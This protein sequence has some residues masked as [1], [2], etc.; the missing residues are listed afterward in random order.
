[1]LNK[2]LYLDTETNGLSWPCLAKVVAVKDTF[3]DK[4]FFSKLDT[5]EERHKLEEVIRGRTVIGWNVGFD[6]SMLQAAGVDVT[7]AALWIDGCELSRLK[8]SDW[9]SYRLKD[10]ARRF[11]LDTSDEEEV[12]ADVATFLEGRLTKSNIASN[13]WR[14]SKVWE[15]CKQDVERTQFMVER[16]KLLSSQDEEFYKVDSQVMAWAANRYVKGVRLD[17]N[18]VEKVYD[19]YVDR[20]NEAI[21]EANS[22]GVPVNSPKALVE[23][24]YLQ[25]PEAG[26]K[27]TNVETLES[28]AD[29]DRLKHYAELTLKFRKARTRLGLMAKMYEATKEPDCRIHPMFAI[30]TKTG[31]LTCRTPNMQ[32]WPRPVRGELGIRDCMIADEGYRLVNFDYSQQELRICCALIGTK[33]LLTMIHSD[34]PHTYMANY[35]V[36]G[37]EAVKALVD[38]ATENGLSLTRDE[39]ARAYSEADYDVVRAEE[40]LFQTKLVRTMTKTIVFSQ[41]YGAGINKVASQLKQPVKAVIGKYY[42][43]QK[44]LSTYQPT[45]NIKCYY[46]TNLTTDSPHKALNRYGQGTGAEISKRTICKI[47]D[48]GID[49][50]ATTHDDFKAQVPINDARSSKEL[51]QPIVEQFVVNNVKMESDYD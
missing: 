33:P 8:H 51:F 21:D 7:V 13:M 20:I 26:I 45:P 3:N 24:F 15:Y 30:T 9:M 2:P 46:G 49:L 5:A 50:L 31:R 44:L 16:L 37:D 1:M 19:L 17:P 35:L 23:F 36:N 18:I 39:A 6:M 22:L 12:H 42:G 43:F 32:Q 40:S 10:L 38:A 47:V 34:D 27:S 11:K 28:L 29:N 25:A 4:Y 41:L 48:A 14:S